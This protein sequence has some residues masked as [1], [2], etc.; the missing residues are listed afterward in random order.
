MISGPADRRKAFQ[1]PGA[2]I[3]FVHRIDGP[4]RSRTAHAAGRCGDGPFT[5]PPA[6]VLAART[7]RRLN[8]DFFS[9]VLSNVGDVQVSRRAVET[10][11]ERIA[12]PIGP[13]LIVASLCHERVAR[14][15]GV[16]AG[17]VGGEIVAAGVNPQDLAEQVVVDVLGVSGSHGVAGPG[18]VGRAAVTRGDVQQPIRPKTQPT[19][20]VV[21][22]RLGEGQYRLSAGRIGEVGVPR[23]LLEADDVGRTAGI[24]E[25]HVEE[26]VRG[27]VRIERHPQQALFVSSREVGDGEKRRRVDHPGRTVEDQDGSRL[28]FE[29]EQPVVVTRR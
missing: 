27:K 3:V 20:V 21:P 29:D 24:G 17:E 11:P 9:R 1:G 2:V 23:H 25:I 16:V 15:Y 7:G 4:G 28:L 10:A 6:V 18:V 5:E 13:N 8:V 14:W 12:E 26:A 22:L 19:S